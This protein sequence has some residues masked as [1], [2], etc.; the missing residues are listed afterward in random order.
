LLVQILVA[1]TTGG[2]YI[3]SAND[4]SVSYECVCVL[5][6][7]FVMRPVVTLSLVLRHHDVSTRVSFFLSQF[8]AVPSGL[9]SI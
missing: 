3:P 7:C 4:F 2:L 5:N 8:Q 6:N 9:V 1:Q